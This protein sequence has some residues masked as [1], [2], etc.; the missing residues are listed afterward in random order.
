MPCH[1]NEAKKRLRRMIW[2]RRGIFDP[3]VVPSSRRRPR[4]RNRKGLGC[5]AQGARN[6]YLQPYIGTIFIRSFALVFLW[7]VAWGD[8]SQNATIALDAAHVFPPSYCP[9]TSKYYSFDA[10]TYYYSSASHSRCA[11]RIPPAACYSHDPWS[12]SCSSSIREARLTWRLKL[13]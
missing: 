8:R 2:G 5:V 3:N 12:I 1:L 10:M 11:R 4:P 7:A 6:H 13:Q 9:F